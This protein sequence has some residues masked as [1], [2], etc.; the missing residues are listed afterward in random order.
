M[1]HRTQDDW[2]RALPKLR[3]VGG[4]L[5]GPCPVC[6]GD[7]RFYVTAQGAA[8]CRHCCPDGGNA[9]AVKALFA[10]AFG[11]GGRHNGGPPPERKPTPPTPSRTQPKALRIIRESRAIEGSPAEA[12]LARVRGITQDDYGVGALRFHPAAE[13]RGR[14]FPALVA[15]VM[16][17][18]RALADVGDDDEPYP[19]RFVA[20]QCV[21]LTADGEKAKHPDLPKNSKPSFG[22]V[23][24]GAV[25]LGAR[26]EGV[27]V[28]A[29][30]IE[31]AISLAALAGVPCHPVATLGAARMAKWNPPKWCGAVLIAADGDP[32]GMRH[33]QAAHRRFTKHG[34]TA[35][36]R[37]FKDGADANNLL[38]WH[39]RTDGHDG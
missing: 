8:F 13:F 4:Q 20:C 27:V 36:V 26:P 18:W 2:R 30:G 1:A 24:Q 23:S 29:E 7:D 5:V 33:A 38:Q 6:G 22:P 28:L 31:N 37:H 35:V 34:L 16:D 32:A 10:A 3:R 15:P 25:Y 11:D 14:V 21:M 17:G 12:Y 39:R 9:E 19:G